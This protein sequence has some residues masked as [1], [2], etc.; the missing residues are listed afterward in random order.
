[1]SKF[2]LR[3]KSKD[4]IEGLLYAYKDCKQLFKQ[5][6]KGNRLN[7]FV[8]DCD[9]AIKNLKEDLKS[10]RVVKQNE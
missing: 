10:C 8:D 9:W 6:K 5:Q 3:K 7:N 1:M 2:I 4:Y